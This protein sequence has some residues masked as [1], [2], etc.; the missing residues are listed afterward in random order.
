[1]M[2]KIL[3]LSAIIVLGLFLSGCIV[4]TLPSGI[5]N[6]EVQVI[7]F[8]Q[9]VNLGTKSYVV[10]NGE[11]CVSDCASCCE[12]CEERQECPTCY[13]FPCYAVKL[14]DIL[15]DYKMSNVGNVDLTVDRVCFTITFDDG[16]Q[17]E[18][19]VDMEVGL[20]VGENIEKEIGIILPIPV[21]RVVFVESKS[22]EFN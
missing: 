7:A 2:K 14:G 16:T 13:T 9:E 11:K 5:N 20:L 12:Q 1:M 8:E 22:V 19:C 17:F 4:P 3:L 21:K 15:V 18:R 10:L 6:V